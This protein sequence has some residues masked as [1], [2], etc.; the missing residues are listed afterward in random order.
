MKKLWI[1]VVVLLSALAWASDKQESIESLKARAGLAQ[2]KDQVELFTRIAERQL[3]SLDQAYNGGTV[4]EA[5]AALADVV[6]Y[7]VKA[8]KVSSETGKRMKQTEIAM[9]K[10]T[11]RLEAIRKTVE[12][13][14]RP[15]LAD[16]VQRL[17]TA[18]SEL[19]NRM[20]RK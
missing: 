7:G 8:A 3:D 1:I 6:T 18:R 14:D 16:A 17:E 20:F 10:I 2:P 15:P 19:L 4:R 12:V 13:D 11:G 9:R 5:Q